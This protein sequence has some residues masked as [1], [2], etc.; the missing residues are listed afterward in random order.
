MEKRVLRFAQDDRQERRRRACGE[1]RL[2]ALVLKGG[3][4]GSF[5]S[6]TMTGKRGD[7][8]EKRVLRFAQ[9]DRRN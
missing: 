3:I 6:L 4:Q 9:D 5:A 2:C 7:E 8:V 1:T